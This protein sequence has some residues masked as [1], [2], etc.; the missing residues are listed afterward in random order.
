MLVLPMARMTSYMIGVLTLLTLYACQNAEP[1]AYQDWTMQVDSILRQSEFNGVVAIAH[2]TVLSYS[3]HQGFSDMER[4]TALQLGDRF[5]IGSISKQIT[6]VM[7]LRAYEQGR[8]RLEDKISDH[9]SDIHQPWAEK[10]DIHQL[11]VH[12]HGIQDLEEPLAFEPGTRFEYS[13]LGY[14]LLARILEVVSGRS[15]EQQ[16]SDLFR[17]IGMTQTYHPDTGP[18]VG[19]VKGHRQNEQGNWEY[20]EHS[21]YNYPAAGA[22]ISSAEDLLRWSHI[23]HTGHLLSPST[24]ELVCTPYATRKHPVF[25]SIEYGYGL[26]FRAGES[27]LEIGAL[28]YAPGFASALYYYPRSG[29]SLVVLENVV[30]SSDDFREV[31][32]THAELMGLLRAAD[33]RKTME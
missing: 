23:L 4:Q 1:R 9:L 3:R 19:L 20:A 15:F 31:F 26:L 14:E 6:A 12:T 16:S 27:D 17:S 10:V 28:G 22:F 30:R 7:V 8:L 21:L 32:G 13:Q 2:D 33:E 5:V 11:L 18:H 24:M 29:R 25:D